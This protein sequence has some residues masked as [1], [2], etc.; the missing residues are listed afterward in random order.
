MLKIVCDALEGVIYVND[1]Q[2]VSIA[3]HKFYNAAKPRTEVRFRE[4]EELA[5]V[6]DP[7][8]E[9]KKRGRPPKRK[10]ID[11]TAEDLV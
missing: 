4:M 11:L 6:F 8:L 10:V 1:S 9:P 7:A 2:I 5:I 3:S